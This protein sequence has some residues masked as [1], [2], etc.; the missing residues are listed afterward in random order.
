MATNYLPNQWEAI[1]NYLLDPDYT[2]DNNAIE[3]TNR[4]ISLSRR[5]SLFFG[6]HD[7]AK[8]A[9]LL[10]SMA[11]SC[12]L[13]NINVF[14]YFTHLLTR[15]A[16]IEPNAS[17]QVLRELLPDRWTKQSTEQM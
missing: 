2:P 10:Y 12:R 6:S 15:M 7:A 17:Y 14:E 13:H 11:C 5:N 16:Y 9:A 4:Y 1:T 8:R 3:R